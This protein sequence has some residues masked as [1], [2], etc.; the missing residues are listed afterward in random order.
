MRSLFA[1]VLEPFSGQS[2]I[3]SAERLD[4]NS[5]QDGVV[6]LQVR[7]GD[8]VDTIIKTDDKPPY[9]E[10]ITSTGIRLKGRL[11]IVR[12][13]AGR[14]VRLWL[15]DGESL[16]AND[17]RLDVQVARY[18]GQIL[19]A[20]RKADDAEQDAFITDAELP[21]GDALQ[22]SWMIVTHGNGFT[23]GYAID[24]VERRDDK[25]TI[26]LGMDH[27]LRIDGAET[28]E[29][30]FPRRNIAGVNRFTIPLYAT[31]VSPAI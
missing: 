27:G 31:F 22:G 17:T 30:F 25:T 2:F 16:Q 4:V 20:I 13:Q 23:H 6:V 26:V 24:R 7:H 14:V 15:F 28:Q 1:A 5:A 9:P 29:V 3:D 21:V 12:Q 19:G 8:T 10:R 11:G 18:E